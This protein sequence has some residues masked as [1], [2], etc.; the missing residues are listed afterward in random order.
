MFMDIYEFLNKVMEVYFW[1]FIEELYYFSSI[2]WRFIIKSDDC[3][4]F[5]GMYDFSIMFNCSDIWIWF[6][7]SKD[8]VNNFIVMKI[9]L[10]DDMIKEIKFYYGMVSNDYDMFNVM[11]F[12]KV[13][14]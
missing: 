1:L 5:E 11:I 3:I 6:Y 13:L 7:I 12:L 4:W 2:Y 9:K 8:L 10:F 14:N